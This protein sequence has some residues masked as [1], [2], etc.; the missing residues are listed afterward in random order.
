MYLIY[1]LFLS[2]IFILLFPCLFIWAI[3]GKHGVLERLGK[4]PNGSKG[5]FASKEVLWFHAA[6]VGEIKL[7]STIVSRVKRRNPAC[8]I[9]VSTLT[10]AGKSEGE[11]SLKGVDLF[12]YLPVDLPI[13]TR[14]VFEKLN[15]S[16]LV[17]VETEVWPNLIRQAK[18][19]GAR[20]VLINGRFSPRSF[21]RYFK[22]RSFFSPVFSLYDLFCMRTEKDA[23]RLMLLGADPRKVRVIGNLKFDTDLTEHQRLDHH[24]LRTDL[25]IP[26]SS[27]IVVAGSTEP[28]EEKM[29]LNAFKKLKGQHPDLLLIL[30]PRH[31]SRIRQVEDDLIESGLKYRRRT[32][33]AE[34]SQAERN[35]DVVLLDTIGELFALYSIAEVAFVGG[36]LIPFG[37]HNILEPAMHSVPVLFGPHMDHFKES[38]ELLGKSGGGIL[39]KDTEELHLKIS[40]LLKDDENRRKVG[41]MAFDFIKRQQGSSDKTVDLILNLINE[42]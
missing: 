32:Q 38:S 21:E 11:R 19:S 42:S 36:S 13:F 29:V 26:T 39:I 20:L 1:N 30:A 27:R 9:V 16:L 15:P 31:L 25:G 10:K 23:Q 8:A 40:E 14:K 3:A 17:L 18:I 6:S 33:I 28:G 12:F 41:Q 4:L 24:K 37:G 35:L 7:L 2:V 5:K 22:L 34:N